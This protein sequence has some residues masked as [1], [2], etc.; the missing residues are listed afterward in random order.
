VLRLKRE[1]GCEKQEREKR[2]CG[3]CRSNGGK[4][5]DGSLVAIPIFQHLPGE[6]KMFD[7]NNLVME[8]GSLYTNMKEFRLAMR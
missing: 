4:G 7:K 3:A 6:R 1:Y 5:C 2:T 8:P